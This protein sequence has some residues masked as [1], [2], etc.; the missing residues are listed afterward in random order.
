[1]AAVAPARHPVRTPDARTTPCNVEHRTFPYETPVVD[2]Q[3]YISPAG[4]QDIRAAAS[5]NAPAHPRRC[6]GSARPLDNAIGLAAP[7]QYCPE[8]HLRG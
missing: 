5:S 3:R 7:G 2:R 1:M 8:M 4:L 6:R